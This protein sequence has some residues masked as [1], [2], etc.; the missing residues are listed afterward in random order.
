[1]AFSTACHNFFNFALMSQSQLSHF[2]LMQHFLN[3]Y[4][5]PNFVHY[6]GHVIKAD[7]CQPILA[8]GLE[9]YDGSLKIAATLR[10]CLN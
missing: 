6:G 9:T 3:S 4:L 8:N 10:D 7:L 2:M 5:Q 1:M